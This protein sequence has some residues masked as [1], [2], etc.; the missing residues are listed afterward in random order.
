MPFG[1]HCENWFEIDLR[2][3]VPMKITQHWSKH[4]HVIIHV[5]CLYAISLVY[6]DM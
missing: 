3:E 5:I 6:L 1:F 4:N 2:I